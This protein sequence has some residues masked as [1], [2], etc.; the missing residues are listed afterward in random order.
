MYLRLNED[1][2]SEDVVFTWLLFWFL[3]KIT[4]LTFVEFVFYCFVKKHITIYLEIKRVCAAIDVWSGTDGSYWK[5]FAITQ[6]WV[7][8]WLYLHIIYSG[9]RGTESPQGYCC[10]YRK[11][12]FIPWWSL[13]TAKM[14]PIIKY[15]LSICSTVNAEIKLWSTPASLLQILCRTPV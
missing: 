14:E 1:S 4:C 12:S 3:W 13:L 2:R 5:V 10:L 11:D 9:H 6:L 15:N 8:H 7:I